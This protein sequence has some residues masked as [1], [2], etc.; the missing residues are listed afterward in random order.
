[1]PEKFLQ[2]NI[3]KVEKA[4]KLD[5]IEVEDPFVRENFDRDFEEYID[6]P[7]SGHKEFLIRQTEKTKK[8]F[9]E[10]H[11]YSDEGED[12]YVDGFP[13]IY[14]TMDYTN[15]LFE[16][17]LLKIALANGILN[18]DKIIIPSIKLDVIYE[19]CEEEACSYY[20]EYISD[21]ICGASFEATDEA[22][23]LLNDISVEDVNP[24]LSLGVWSKLCDK[25]EKKFMNF[26]E[27]SKK[28]EN[29]IPMGLLHL[30][31]G[32][33]D[34]VS[35]NYRFKIEK[36]ECGDVDFKLV[37]LDFAGGRGKTPPEGG[38]IGR[39]LFFEHSKEDVL[40]YWLLVK[41]FIVRNNLVNRVIEMAPFPLEIKNKKRD[42]VLLNMD[43]MEKLIDAEFEH[44][45]EK[46][47][48]N[49]AQK[50]ANNLLK[51]RR[52]EQYARKI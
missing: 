31:A 33:M 14:D 47:R 35:T 20:S 12:K 50:I 36:T 18:K 16:S 17:N 51:Q 4:E 7:Y 46:K 3:Q 43:N 41:D 39:T 29:A 25:A 49:E 48:E 30:V 21:T 42:E 1:M 15:E 34:R 24:P 10:K 45:E 11:P 9:V 40:R 44:I 19:G 37:A 13:L 28:S 52:E 8:L 27:E 23:A 6:T 5:I 38:T 26:L 32:D 22:V 2:S